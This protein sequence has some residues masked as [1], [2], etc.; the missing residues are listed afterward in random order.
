M[1]KEASA[2]SLRA[3]NEAAALKLREKAS[4]SNKLL[5]EQSRLAVLVE[6][7][8][9]EG[10]TRTVELDANISQLEEESKRKEGEIEALKR[11]ASELREEIKREEG[12]IKEEQR[13]AQR[14]RN[15]KELTALAHSEHEALLKEREREQNILNSTTKARSAYASR[16]SLEILQ[17]EL[18]RHH[19]PKA[20]SLDG[21]TN[22]SEKLRWRNTQLAANIL[23]LK[24]LAAEAE[25]REERALG[26]S[27]RKRDQLTNS[28]LET[29]K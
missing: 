9:K 20:A 4:A 10:Q 16:D 15:Y 2:A 19:N 26:E 18:S 24:G 14:Q 28:K 27:K 7:A 6:Q 29:D 3:D 21:R 22:E 8:Q 23:R 13:R 1:E 17:R 11:A 12:R 25:G 5:A